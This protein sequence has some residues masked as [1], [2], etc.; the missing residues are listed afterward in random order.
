MIKKV[1]VA[2][3]RLP[4]VG[5]HGPALELG[6]DTVLP[7]GHVRLLGVT[8]S[9]DLSLD[10]HVSVVCAKSF[11]WL[12]RLRRVR[13]SLDA[14]SA[15]TLVHAFVT[16]KVDYCNLLLAGSPASVADRLR[17]VVNA[18]AR[19]VGGTGGYDR[20]LTQL[21]RS[22]L[23]WLDVADRVTCG[24]S[25]TV[26]GCLRGRAPDCLSGLCVPVARVAGR[27]RL[28]SAGRHLLVVPGFQ[29]H[30]CGRRAFAVAGPATWNS[31]SVELRDPDLGVAAFG[32]SLRTFLF[33]RYSVH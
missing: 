13:R 8:L 10:R 15:A 5:F 26:F 21:L 33:R 3:T 24:L 6:A 4:S 1:K 29:L 17:R 16:S 11:Y 23:H 28:R 7:C 31:L 25:L 18:A 19:V 22:E 32:R 27:Q 2:R 14:E 30:T 9:A 12:R 20:G